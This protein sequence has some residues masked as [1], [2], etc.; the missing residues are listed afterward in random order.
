MFPV[1]RVLSLSA[2]VATG[3]FA[4]VYGQTA[5]PPATQQKPAD[6]AGDTS[7]PHQ[8]QLDDQHRVITAGGFVK[9]GPLVFEDVSEKAG[10]SKWSY[11]MGTPAKDYIIETKGS[12]V[13]LRDYDIRRLVSTSI[14]STDRPL[15]RS[16]AK[17]RRRMPL[18]FTTIMTALS[19]M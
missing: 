9:S 10:L 7:S 17:K 16:A 4:T 8:I 12:G 3:L 14:S 6:S 1:K 5:T 2:V 15:T 19:R 11:K 13:C 18:S